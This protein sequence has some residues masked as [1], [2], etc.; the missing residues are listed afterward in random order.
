MLSFFFL[1]TQRQKVEADF[2]DLLAE[3]SD[4]EIGEL[5][6]PADEI[7]AT[8][9]G[10]VGID[11]GDDYI[12][13]IL[14]D[15]LRAKIADDEGLLVSTTRNENRGKDIMPMPSQ[16]FFLLTTDATTINLSRTAPPS[17]NSLQGL[18]GIKNTLGGLFKK[19][20]EGADKESSSSLEQ[21][22]EGADVVEEEEQQVETPEQFE[23]YISKHEYLGVSQV[24]QVQFALVHSNA[25]HA[26]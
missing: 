26:C 1:Y 23:E 5:E 10:Q 6:D 24:M 21:E 9:G 15:F 14:D 12:E 3:Y 18:F 11:G 4:D 22:D 7:A 13:D 17:D 25:A 8:R 16:F 20:M 19:R 2:E